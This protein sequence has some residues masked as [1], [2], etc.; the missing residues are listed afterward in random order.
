MTFSA[1]SFSERTSD[2]GQ[3]EI[4]SL[5]INVAGRS[6][7]NRLGDDFPLAYLKK[8]LGRERENGRGRCPSSHK[9]REAAGQLLSGRLGNPPSNCHPRNAALK[10]LREIH[11]I[12]VSGQDV[13]L[14]AL[15]G[16]AGSQALVMLGVKGLATVE[17][18]RLCRAGVVGEG[19][20]R[21]V[22]GVPAGQCGWYSS[23]RGAGFGMRHQHTQ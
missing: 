22:G 1:R 20:T 9:A 10:A 4:V 6:A 5:G 16:V 19:R 8:A 3:S 2:L 7:F 23:F 11:L 17:T 14:N 21:P 15:N 13:L 18:I 12:A